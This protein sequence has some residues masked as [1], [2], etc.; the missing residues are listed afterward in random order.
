MVAEFCFYN[1]LC[2]NRFIKCKIIE[3]H[4]HGT[5]CKIIVHATFFFTALVIR[6][7]RH[8]CIEAC[9]AFDA[10]SILSISFLATLSSLDRLAASWIN[11]ANKDMTHFRAITPL[12]GAYHFSNHKI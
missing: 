9:A 2:A 8:Q 7:F 11:G 10:V 5:L 1:T 3:S 4:G 12:F 6:I